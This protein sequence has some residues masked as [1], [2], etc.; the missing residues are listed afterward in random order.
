MFNRMNILDAY[1][2]FAS[3]FHGGQGSKEYLIFGRLD[4]LGY[5][6]S[7][8]LSFENMSLEVREIYN[9]LGIKT[10]LLPDDYEPCA[11]CGFDHDYE[12]EHAQ[13]V[14]HSDWDD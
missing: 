2:M 12:Y 6:P 10:G 1:Y 9:N 4:K 7:S 8:L 11:T 3:H 14:D 13:K 5:K